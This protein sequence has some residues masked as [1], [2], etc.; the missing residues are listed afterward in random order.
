[1]N[2]IQWKSDVNA[3]FIATKGRRQLLPEH[4]AVMSFMSWYLHHTKEKCLSR[5]YDIGGE[6]K[7]AV[8][9]IYDTVGTKIWITGKNSHLVLKLS[10]ILLRIPS[11]DVRLISQ[12]SLFD[13]LHQ[14]VFVVL[15]KEKRRQWG[16]S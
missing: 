1:M 14:K 12:V 15:K 2:E 10:K 9:T 6:K 11:L 4:P 16:K 5:D 13:V 7:A 8:R 3:I